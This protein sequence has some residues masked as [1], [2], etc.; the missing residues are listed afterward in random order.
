VLAAGLYLGRQ[1]WRFFSPSVRLQANAAWNALVF[2]LNG[3]VFIIIGLQLP[4]VLNGIGGYHRAQLI[5]YGGILSAFLIVLRLGWTFPAAWLAHFVRTRLRHEEEPWLGGRLV[6]VVGWTGM[7]GVI[8]LAAA[9]SLPH[10]LANGTA[11]PQRSL[12]VF[13]TFSVILVTLVFQGLSLPS[14]VRAFKLAAT[15]GHGCEQDEARSLIIEA[16]LA[17]LEESRANDDPAFG[18]VYDDL[19]QHYRRMLASLKC[20]P[21]NADGATPEHYPRYLEVS[22]DLLNVERQT[23]LRLRREGR[24]G[25]EILRDIQREMDLTEVRLAAAEQRAKQSGDKS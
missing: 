2:I 7:R 11:F 14:L 5:L 19:G 1:S 23:A 6:F 24:I 15:E 3:L 18:E 10:A 12:I 20:L 8:A 4:Y 22:R 16:A 17:R 21:A 25:D 9:L 13:L